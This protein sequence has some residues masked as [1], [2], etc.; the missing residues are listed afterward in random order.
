[1]LF[2]SFTSKYVEFAFAPINIIYA[3]PHIV[4]ALERFY[5]FA[6][7]QSSL[8]Q[9]WVRQYTSTMKTD[10]RYSSSDCFEPFP[11]PPDE[12]ILSLESIGEQYY[13]TRHQIMISRQEGLTDTYNRFHDPHEHSTDIAQLRALHV[14]MDHA[15]AAAY[16]WSDFDVQYDFY[17]TPQG[18]RYTM[19]EES[20]REVLKRLLALN[21]E[22]AAEEQ[23]ILAGLPKPKKGKKS[24]Q[25]AASAPAAPEVEPLDENAPPPDQLDLFDDGSPKQGRLL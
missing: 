18:V 10:I 24:A 16:G 4:F 21:F 13:E 3:G 2:H 25:A 17:E 23:S 12:A 9:I 11:F 15:V 14:E 20:R 7:L 5:H 19:P 6:S 8:H 1:M 22:R